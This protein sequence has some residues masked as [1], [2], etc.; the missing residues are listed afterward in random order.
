MGLVASIVFN[1]SCGDKTLKVDLFPG[2]VYRLMP[3]M[4]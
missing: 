4:D 2:R 1:L 3:I